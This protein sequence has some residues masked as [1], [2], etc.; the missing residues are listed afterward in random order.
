M[1]SFFDFEW[2]DNKRSTNAA[3]HGI[4]FANAASVFEDPRQLMFRSSHRS[5]E[6]RLLS[7]G[8]MQ[9]RLIAVVFIRRADKIRIIS[10]RHARKSERMRYER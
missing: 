1:P 9:G 10:A 4:D 3:K 5:G 6:E 8:M 2:D 7:I